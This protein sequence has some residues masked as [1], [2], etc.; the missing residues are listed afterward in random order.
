MLSPAH[1]TS[2][3]DTASPPVN[4]RETT[5]P[6][7]SIASVTRRGLVLYS[8]RNLE[9]GSDLHLGLHIR[10][11]SHQEHRSHSHFIDV[12][13]FVVSSCLHAV[14]GTTL[15]E[16]TL[17]YDRMP[18]DQKRLLSSVPLSAIKATAYNGLH[19]YEAP[20]PCA[21]SRCVLGLN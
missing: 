12:H 7:L 3:F 8:R 20:D 11:K 6:L 17:L 16:I 13:G 2:S 15:F 21:Q 14:R 1:L 10:L 5:S 9:I 4:P 19:A 18:T